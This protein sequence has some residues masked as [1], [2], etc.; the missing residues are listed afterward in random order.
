MAIET[1]GPHVA[2]GTHKEISILKDNRGIDM[3]Y[4]PINLHLLQKV[5]ALTEKYL[6]EERDYLPG[7]TEYCHFLLEC[8]MPPN[9]RSQPTLAKQMIRKLLDRICGD[10]RQK[11]AQLAVVSNAIPPPTTPCSSECPSSVSTTATT[12]PVGITVVLNVIPSPTT[13]P[14]SESTSSSSTTATAQ[15]SATVPIETVEP[16]STSAQHAATVTTGVTNLNSTPHALMNPS[17][18]D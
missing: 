16:P 18:V 2:E 5:Q 15:I 1:E 9:I 11:R 13:T 6:Y 3:D 12:I 7:E 17:H 10:L 14:S 4:Q 8:C